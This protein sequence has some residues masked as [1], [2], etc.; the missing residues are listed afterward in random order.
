MT[1]R[2][3]LALAAAGLI[4]LLQGCATT[5]EATTDFDSGFD[6]SKVQRIAILPIDRTQLSTIRVS[7]M[8]VDRINQAIAA[9]LTRK[10][11]TMVEDRG[12][13]DV[14]LT[15]HL[16]TEERMDVRNYNSMAYYNCWRCGPSVSD[17]SVHQYTQ[18][19]FIVDLIDPLR[20]R[21]VWRSRISSRLNPDPDP[22][23]GP[24]RR[25][26]AA[27]AVFAEFPPPR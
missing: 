14:L 24:E 18:G 10:G 5:L 3:L 7:D 15:W 23:K 20:N 17:V 25:A 4:V 9:E 12:A 13:A 19:T 22:N 27:R 2:T 1:V 8:Q 11:F 21:S 6:F 26:E 16:V